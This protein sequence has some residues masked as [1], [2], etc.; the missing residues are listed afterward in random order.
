MTDV[1]A[2]TSR[3]QHNSRSHLSPN[4][5]TCYY[6]S[7]GM[8]ADELTKD[9]PHDPHDESSGARSL[10]PP[11]FVHR[12]LP[13]AF[14]HDTPSSYRSMRPLGLSN[15]DFR[16]TIRCLQAGNGFDLRYRTEC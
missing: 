3:N 16:A 12:L 5:G 10:Y 14:R 2:Y 8:L 11:S 6:D 4:V 9:L 13:L 15:R 1:T 7:P